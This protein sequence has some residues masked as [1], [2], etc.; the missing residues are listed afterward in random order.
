MEIL[1]ITCM[2]LAPQFSRTN[3]L[4]SPQVPEVP[5]GQSVNNQVLAYR[6]RLNQPIPEP[7]HQSTK[8]PGSELCHHD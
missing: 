3:C 8:E 5:L 1:S 6:I 2:Q 4:V 7:K